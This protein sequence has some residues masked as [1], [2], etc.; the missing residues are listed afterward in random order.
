MVIAREKKSKLVKNRDR[1][2][3]LYVLPFAVGFLLLI[4]IPMLQSL[5]Y[6]FNEL[7]FD[8]KINVNFVGLE[9]YKRAFL[10]DTEYRKMLISSVTDILM[11]APII[12]IFSMLVAILLNGEF[13]GRSI[14]QII[15]FVPIFAS[16]GILESLFA[17][18]R[19]RASIIG[20]ESM[21]E[22][23]ASSVTF[24]TQAIN[25]F[26]LSIDFPSQ[27]VDYI[28]YAITNILSVINSSGIQILVFLIALKSI[29]ASLYEASDVEGAT[30]WEGFWKIT[31]PMVL[32][33]AMVNVVYT[34]IDLFVNNNNT[35]MKTVYNYNF[36]SFQFGYAASL[37]WSYFVVILVVLALFC[38]LVS[39]VIKHYD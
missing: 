14:F 33:L 37:S 2:G 10:V 30:A 11:K 22:G 24:N 36:R 7:V 3:Y 38:F 1:K 13:K 4:F 5:W 39:R 8:G 27:F 23:A 15:F 17:N 12:L 19:F 20:A 9:N 28:M 35:I 34:V 26:L 25:Q 18:D 21:T 6:S 31:F 29:P 16:S 32:P